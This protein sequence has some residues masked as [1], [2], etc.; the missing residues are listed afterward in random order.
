MFDM[1]L[2]FTFHTFL[3][4]IDPDI[5]PHLTHGCHGYERPCILPSVVSGLLARHVNIREGYLTLI[6]QL[7]TSIQPK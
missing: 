3:H 2:Q 6:A 7:L 5:T 1:F 4:S